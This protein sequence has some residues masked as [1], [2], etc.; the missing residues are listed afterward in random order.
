M[1]TDTIAAVATAPGRAA[2]GIVRVSGP[3]VRRIASAILDRPLA[4]R[5]ATIGEFRD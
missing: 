1:A 4:P 2:V 3:L 5:Q